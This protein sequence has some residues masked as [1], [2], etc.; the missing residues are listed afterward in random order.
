MRSTVADFYTKCNQCHWAWN[1]QGLYS[2]KTV[3]A[4]LKVNNNRQK[5][6]KAKTQWNHSALLFW[7]FSSFFFL[8]CEA[9]F[10]TTV[11]SRKPKKVCL[12]YFKA[13]SSTCIH[14][15][16]SGSFHSGRWGWRFKET[17][18]LTYD[19]NHCLKVS[20]CLQLNRQP[21]TEEK[22]EMS[23][24]TYSQVQLAKD[25][26]RW[27]QPLFHTA[28]LWYNAEIIFFERN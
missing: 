15:G 20:Y 14:L 12:R 17:I 27:L 26:E 11:F 24:S 25:W 19:N 1:Q 18:S 22:K 3:K 2:N 9:G 21:F 10:E 28:G 5:I 23:S 4:E 7:L 6:K 16:T 8:Q 13:H